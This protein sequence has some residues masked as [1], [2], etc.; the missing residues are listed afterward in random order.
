MDKDL[1]MRERRIKWK[2][3]EK[4]KREREKGRR[5]KMTNSKIWMR[6]WNGGE[7]KKGMEEEEWKRRRIKKGKLKGE[8]EREEGEEERGRG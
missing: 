7:W 6:G 1:T 8:R 2:M 5:V 3:V 4:A